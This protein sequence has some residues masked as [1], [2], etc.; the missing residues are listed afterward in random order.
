LSDDTFCGLCGRKAQAED[1][2]QAE[3]NEESMSSVFFGEL[4]AEAEVD[5]ARAGGQDGALAQEDI[6]E[7]FRRGQED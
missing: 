2:S 5:K 3:E 1:V 4:M 6:S 7:M